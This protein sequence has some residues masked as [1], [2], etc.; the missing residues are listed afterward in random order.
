MQGKHN[1]FILVSVAQF[2]PNFQFILPPLK[3][4]LI[5]SLQVLL[6]SLRG[7]DILEHPVESCDP[8]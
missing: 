5:N 1:T 4:S 6:V 8:S 3:Y 2:L 7:K